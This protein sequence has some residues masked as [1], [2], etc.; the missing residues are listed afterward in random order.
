MG[1]YYQ[2][3]LVDPE[4]LGDE[5]VWANLR[6]M[7]GFGA[8][9]PIANLPRAVNNDWKVKVA[10]ALNSR[11]ISLEHKIEI[12]DLINKNWRAY[13]HHTGHRWNPQ[14]TF[15][16][17]ADRFAGPTEIVF[18]NAISKSKGKV[19][20]GRDIRPSHPKLKPKNTGKLRKDHKNLQRLLD[21]IITNNH[22]FKIVDYLFLDS[23]DNVNLERGRA[24]QWKSVYDVI[25]RIDE[26]NP[27]SDAVVEV[28]SCADP[29]WTDDNYLDAFNKQIKG[30]EVEVK[31]ISWMHKKYNGSYIGKHSRINIDD[32]PHERYFLA[33]HAGIA[34]NRGIGYGRGYYSRYNFLAQNELGEIRKD[35]KIPEGGGLKGQ[36]Y[37]LHWAHTINP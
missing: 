29:N 21:P 36:S 15:L 12:E 24:R 11:S 37:W 1:D 6:Q 20:A 17:N 33:R 19:L 18:T 34:I 28:H 22:H 25:R 16:E 26:V 3:A 2:T 27:G 4:L 14:A 23:L 10:E 30:V 32:D 5:M 31:L 7:V 13:I 8:G 9:R 35:F